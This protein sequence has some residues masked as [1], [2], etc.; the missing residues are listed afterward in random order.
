MSG[1]LT[2][3]M[4]Q[5]QLPAGVGYT[6]LMT[7]YNRAVETARPDALF[8]DPHAVRFAAIAGDTTQVGLPRLGPPEGATSEL[9]TGLNAYLAARTV[10]YDRALLAALSQGTRQVVLP[11]AGLDTR[12]Y[13]MALPGDTTLYEVDTPAVHD[14]KTTV[15]DGTEPA[16]RRVVVE[17]DLRAD[18]AA[19]LTAAGF[20]RTRPTIW[21][22][23]GLLMYF[24]VPAANTL[25]GTVSALSTPGRE[26]G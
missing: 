22:L 5:I 9:W 20:D 17:A 10:Y 15:L 25:L 26:P 6:G 21:V 14:F 23:E 24:P 2:E 12:A 7:A 1:R 3:N 18:W 19:A 13:R 8:T 4:T 16:V 11:G